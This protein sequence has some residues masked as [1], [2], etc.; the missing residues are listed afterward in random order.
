MLATQAVIDAERPG[1]QVGEDAM[2]PRQDDVGGHRADDVRV[3]G[4]A[5]GAGIAGPAV[6]PGGGAGF[7]VGSDE[8]VQAFGRSSPRSRR[9]APGRVRRRAPRRRR[10]PASCPGGCARVRRRAVRPC[11]ARGSSSRRSPPGRPAGDGPGA[12]IARRSL[13]QSSQADLYD[14][15]PSCSCS[16]RAAMPLEWVAIR[17]AA[18]NQT[19]SGSFEACI[20]VPA[21]TEVCRPQPAHSRVNACRRAPSPWPRSRAAEPVRPAT[22]PIRRARRSS[23]KRR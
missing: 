5:G 13:A 21:V 23:G 14:P 1:L 19:V 10:R 16:C 9:A 6:G 15:S 17:Y 8:G 20:T 2:G 18:Q 11:G 12:T 3:V 7:D 4:D 22:A